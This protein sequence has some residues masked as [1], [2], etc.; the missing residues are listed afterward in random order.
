[1]SDSFVHLHLH[2]EYS[3]LDGAVKIADLMAKVNRCKMPAVAMTDHGNLYGA[4]DFYKQ[5]SKAGVKPIIGSEVY[6]SPGSMYEKKKVPG[7][8]NAHHLTLLA[9]NAVGYENL[10]RLVSQAHLDGFYYKPRIDKEALNKYSEGIICLSGCINGEINYWIQQDQLDIA[11]EKLSEFVDIYGKD[12]FYLEMHDH[13]MDQQRL[14]N[15][16]LLEFCGEF[17]LKPVAA[18]DVHF[19]NR[20]DHEAHDVL[21]CIGTGKMVLDENRMRY[22][23]EVHFKT[24]KEMRQLFKEVPVACDNTLEIA[25]KIDFDM[26]LDST[27]SE[28][29]PEYE[30]NLASSREDYF[31]ELCEEGLVERYGS[32]RAKND[33]EL[34]NRLDYEIGIMER[35]GFVSYFLITWD[36]I[37]WAKDNKIPVGPGRGSAAGSLVAYVLGITDLDPLRYGLIFERFLN[38]ERVSPP[39]VDVDFCQTRRPE[40]IEYVR[41]KYGEKCVSHIITFGTLGA[42]SVVRDVGRVMGWS[43]GEADRIAKMIPNELGITLTSARKKNPE[44]KEAIAS[45]PATEQLWEYST[46]LEGLTRGVGIHAAGIVIGDCEL[47][48]HVP[49]TR[50]NENEVVTQYAMKPLTDL[51]MLKMDFLGLKTLTV[52]QDAVDIINIKQSNFDISNIPIDDKKTFALLNAGETCGVFQ[53]ESGGMVALCKQFGVNRIEDIIALIA[54]YRPGP[55]ELIPDFIDRKKGKKKVEYLH[56]LLEEV[57]KETH[58]ILIYQEQVQKAANVL[59]GYSLGD[60]DLLRRAMG[61]KDPDEM[62]K[63]RTIFVEGCKKFN[64]IADKK[65]NGIFDLLEKFAG[66][67]FNKSH[68]AAYGLISYQT[69]Y[70]KA[71]YPVEFMSALLSNEINNTDKISVF[72]EECKSMGIK[73]LPPDVNKSQLKFSPEYSEEDNIDSIRYGLAAIK[74]VGSAAMNLAVTERNQSGDYSSAD[75]FARR[76]ESRSVNK[77]ILES[78][79]KAGAFDF[80]EEERA[81]IFS[82]IDTIISAASLAQKDR[83]SGQTS[84]FD[85]DTDY[86]SSQTNMFNNVEVEFEPWNEDEILAAERELLGFYVT[87]HPLDSYR[88]YFSSGNYRRLSELQDLRENKKYSFMGR[89]AGLEK[90]FTKK[91]GKPFAKLNFEEFTG[92]TEVMVWS[93]VFVRSTEVLQVGAVIELLGKVELDSRT[94]TKRLTAEKIT[95]ISKPIVDSNS[96][97]EESIVNESLLK[98]SDS[99]RNE[100][101]KPG[102][103]VYLKSGVHDK[104]DLHKIRDILMDHPGDN[105]VRIQYT[106]SNGSTVWLKAGPRYLV[107]DCENLRA[108]LANWMR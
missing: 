94:E 24:A 88:A 106:T 18:N 104:S 102:V 8:P 53:L 38:P 58:G 93:E 16:Q 45:E 89:I 20:K 100:K 69:A 73:V 76:L 11:R 59:A 87:G 32:E 1:M 43:Y 83:V 7:L 68:S 13:G 90:M 75:D 33:E 15:R 91:A 49:L 47:D 72:V 39:D 46:F 74:N 54:L 10:V 22:S 98:P 82:R 81:S 40:V 23:P 6:L 80:S 101:Q 26:V 62:A 85:E 63:Q 86:G 34:R 12:D 56:P 30:V 64:E 27:S 21:I 19:L 5:A 66:Y 51:G 50:G 29:Y 42:K 96:K 71:N 105:T 14:C 78:L 77:K 99:L 3:L 28:R 107:N 92:Q 95:P 84:L 97:I 25:E 65:A 31:R 48:V 36:F 37:K 79:T 35:M 9:K 44:L 55:M 60:A 57:S 67:G 41:Q 2:T 4:I 108:E 103:N 52:I 61:K 17:S 70:L